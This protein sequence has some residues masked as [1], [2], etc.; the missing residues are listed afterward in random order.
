MDTI[1]SDLARE[2]F[3]VELTSADADKLRGFAYSYLGLTALAA[4]GPTG[5][6]WKV[7]MVRAELER[8]GLGELF[9]FERV[10]VQREYSTSGLSVNGIDAA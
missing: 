4:A 3:A 1:F 10:A 9:E 6:E 7:E 5:S 2:R 8:R